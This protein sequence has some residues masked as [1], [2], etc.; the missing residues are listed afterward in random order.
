VEAS[1]RAR[2][3]HASTHFQLMC[4]LFTSTEPATIRLIYGG[5]LKLAIGWSM[6][7]DTMGV[8]GNYY[9]KRAIVAQV[10]LGANLPE[11]AIYPLNHS[12]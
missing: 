3:V 7:T 8:Y 4:L 2:D 5:V 1:A 11:D 12:S 6:N 10:G 9:L